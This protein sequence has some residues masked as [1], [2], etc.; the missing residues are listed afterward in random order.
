M[1]RARPRP[2]GWTGNGA[3]AWLRAVPD[4]LLQW[5]P[6]F[7][8]R[9]WARTPTAL[10]WQPDRLWPGDPARGQDMLR[11]R[12]VLSGQDIAAA[13]PLDDG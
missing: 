10:E 13:R 5:P 4:V 6:F 7:R 8:A 12:F 2:L 9:F 1:M 3:G 11:G